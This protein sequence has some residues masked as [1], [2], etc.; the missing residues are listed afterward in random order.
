VCAWLEA[1]FIELQLFVFMAK[2][3]V[4]DTPKVPLLCSQGSA[5]LL[6]EIQVEGEELTFRHGDG[7]LYAQGF[8][9]LSGKLTVFWFTKLQS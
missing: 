9:V 7:R 5:P 4:V 2:F 3:V 8:A 6:L 1:N